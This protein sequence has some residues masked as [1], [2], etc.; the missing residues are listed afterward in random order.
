LIAS[1]EY[2]F[3]LPKT[4]QIE[5]QPRK[6]LGK[7]FRW[8]PQQLY[9]RPDWDLIFRTFIDFGRTDITDRESSYENN[10]QLMGT[11]LGVELQFTRRINLRVDWGVALDDVQSGDE[12]VKGGDSRIHFVGTVLF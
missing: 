1:T 4:F 12:D 2:R 7:P 10:Q 8:A 3:H 9:S 5:R 6:L 11:G